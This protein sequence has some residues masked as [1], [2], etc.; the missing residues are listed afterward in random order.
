MMNMWT[1]YDHPR[2]FP[3]FYVARLFKV[4]AEGTR[5]TVE[6]VLSSSLDE[7]RRS[8]CLLGLTCLNRSPEDDPLIVEVWL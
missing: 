3:D 4:D 5:A 7:I 1:I 8:M 2:D 6:V